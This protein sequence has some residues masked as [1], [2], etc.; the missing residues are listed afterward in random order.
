MPDKD[1]IRGRLGFGVKPGM[2]TRATVA[3]NSA[4]GALAGGDRRERAGA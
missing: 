3:A 4:A 1:R 2:I